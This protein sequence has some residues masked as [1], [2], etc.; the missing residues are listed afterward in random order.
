[1]AILHIPPEKRRWVRKIGTDKTF[2]MTTAFAE[3]L[4]K[5][6]VEV[7]YIQAMALR[8][9]LDESN[10]RKAQANQ[11]KEI[12]LAQSANRRRGVTKAA[13]VVSDIDISAAIPKAMTPD[14]AMKK[15]LAEGGDDDGVRMTD[16]LEDMTRNEL[17][18]LISE[19]QLP[20]KK[21]GNKEDI[22]VAIRKART[23][24]KDASVDPGVDIPPL[25]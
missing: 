8:K 4:G 20:V 16:G 14:D 7:T 11:I 25:E 23:D 1:M 10:V 15:V 12:A 2:Q 3:R 21:Q 13:D 19:E 17:F 9:R 5:D 22:V 24:L 6:M 18:N